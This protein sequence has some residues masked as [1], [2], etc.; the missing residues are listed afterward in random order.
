VLETPSDQLHPGFC[1]NIADL[2][3]VIAPEN[4]R[5]GRRRKH[6]NIPGAQRLTLGLHDVL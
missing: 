2:V 1:N 4:V 5:R 3:V 6:G